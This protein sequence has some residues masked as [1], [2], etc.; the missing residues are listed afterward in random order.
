MESVTLRYVTETENIA[1]RA[2]L[3]SRLIIFAF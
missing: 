3:L 2:G 1:Q